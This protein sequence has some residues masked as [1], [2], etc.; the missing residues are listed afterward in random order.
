MRQ[1]RDFVA[2]ELTRLGLEV[3]VVDPNQATLRVRSARREIEVQVRSLRRRSDPA[4]WP[5]HRFQ[6]RADLYAALLVAQPG[7]PVRTYLIPSNTWLG[8]GP[9]FVNRG[10][11][12]GVSDPE[13]GIN[14][15]A[16]ALPALE[17]FELA[18]VA[19]AL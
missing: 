14:V 4:Y 6:A 7:A 16:R 13:W 18:R 8:A 11:E 15:S 10:Y 2:D 12:D 9:P 3:S 17:P 5:K 1:A 19:A